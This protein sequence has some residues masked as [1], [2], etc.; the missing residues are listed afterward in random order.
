[1]QMIEASREV[2]NSTKVLI[3]DLMLEHENGLACPEFCNAFHDKMGYKLEFQSFGFHNLLDF[4]YYGLGD[5]VDLSIN[6]VGYGIE[7]IIYSAG[8][9]QTTQP[10]Q[11]IKDNDL[12]GVDPTSEGQSKDMVFIFISLV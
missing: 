4:L 3:K 5:T 10:D 12:T 2:P 11:I 8:D 1:M 7:W 6:D 9:V